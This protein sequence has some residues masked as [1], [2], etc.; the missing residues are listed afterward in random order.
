MARKKKTATKTATH[1]EVMQDMTLIESMG[2]VGEQLQEIQERMVDTDYKLYHAVGEFVAAT[3]ETIEVL[4]QQVPNEPEAIESVAAKAIR[5]LEEVYET[6][7]HLKSYGDSDT[8]QELQKKAEAI[9]YEAEEARLFLE[10]EA[11]PEPQ[12][13]PVK[14]AQPTSKYVCWNYQQESDTTYLYLANSHEEAKE[15]HKQHKED[16]S[17]WGYGLY[18]KAPKIG[19][20]V[21]VK[22]PQPESK[23]EPVKPEPVDQSK[24]SKTKKELAQKRLDEILRA[25]PEYR[26]FLPR[27]LRLEGALKFIEDYG[28]LV[29]EVEPIKLHPNQ[30]PAKAGKVKKAEVK[31]EVTEPEYIGKVE[32]S[33]KS[34]V[35]YAYRDLQKILK[36][37]RIAGKEVNCRLNGKR[38]VLQAEAVRL[39]LL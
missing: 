26:M 7:Q 39:G 13:E 35:A 38:E 23:P 3:N 14:P 17:P 24:V 20:V 6:I 33:S 5:Q 19:K 15:I 12:P 10:R 1:T 34:G 2:Y 31:A 27:P 36:E 29:P 9:M 30:S 8:L 21:T 11:K 28:H 37:A 18:E 25:F 4:A 22:A 32:K 16:L